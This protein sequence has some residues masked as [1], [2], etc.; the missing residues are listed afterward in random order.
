MQYADFQIAATFT[1]VGY[2]MQWDSLFSGQ[3]VMHL[4]MLERLVRVLLYLCCYKQYPVIF[5]ISISFS[6]SVLEN[7][8]KKNIKLYVVAML[9]L[10]GLFL[11][12]LI[13]F[14]QD[15]HNLGL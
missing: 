2:L 15:Q 11:H 12:Q 13:S 9:G 8:V 14:N 4:A 7:Y 6:L 3:F 5:V 1:Y 10:F